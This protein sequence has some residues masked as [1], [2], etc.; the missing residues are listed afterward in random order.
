MPPAC[1]NATLTTGKPIIYL[2]EFTPFI[3]A[4]GRFTNARSMSLECCQK[5]TMAQEGADGYYYDIDAATCWLVQ[6]PLHPS[7]DMSPVKLAALLD[8]VPAG[9]QF[10]QLKPA[11]VP[12]VLLQDVTL[13]R[14]TSQDTAKYNLLNDPEAVKRAT[15]L[16]KS[17]ENSVAVLILDTGNEAFLRIWLHFWYMATSTFRNVIIIAQDLLLYATM[18]ALLPNQVLL[19]SAALTDPNLNTVPAKIRSK[20]FGERTK[21]RH[22]QLA[23]VAATGVNVLYADA[24]ALL[25][26]NLFETLSNSTQIRAARDKAK[27]CAGMIYIPYNITS[28]Q[29]HLLTDTLMIVRAPS[30]VNDQ[31]DFNTAIKYMS[32]H[33]R[34]LPPDSYPSALYFWGKLEKNVTEAE[35]LAQPAMKGVC[36]LHN[37]FIVGA[38]NKAKRFREYGF[39]QNPVTADHPGI[40]ELQSR[41]SA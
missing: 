9:C 28:L 25:F 8:P 35:A 29:T 40:K 3:T 20:A 5:L 23:V 2:P 17:K 18:N 15:H 32:K 21:R 22:Y 31:I 41:R 11:R 12:A 37:N 26:C 16:C 34:Q 4:A 6:A 30:V 10:V 14:N 39:D 33:F 1:D 38:G 24:D 19:E 36:Y 27:M 13:Y 7:A